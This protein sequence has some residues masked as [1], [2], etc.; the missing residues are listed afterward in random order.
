MSGLFRLLLVAQSRSQERRQG[1]WVLRSARRRACTPT[2]TLTTELRGPC[3][4]RTREAYA[5]CLFEQPDA[6]TQK[7]QQHERG[8]RLCGRP[9][10]DGARSAAEIDGRNAVT[11]F[12]A[13]RSVAQVR[14]AQAKF[15]SS[16]RSR[17]RRFRAAN[18]DHDEPTR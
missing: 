14:A 18:D 3:A 15:G 11:D 13:K 17:C 2:A 9:D 4:G 5:A 1:D 12:I 6:Y 10:F 7:Q 8:F 16:G